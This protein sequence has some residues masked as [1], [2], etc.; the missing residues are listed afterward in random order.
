MKPISV[1][2]LWLWRRN[3]RKSIDDGVAVIGAKPVAYASANPH[4]SLD[5]SAGLLGIGR[6]ALRRVAVE[7]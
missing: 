1:A 3:S 4:H 5:K 6:K 7:R 2:W